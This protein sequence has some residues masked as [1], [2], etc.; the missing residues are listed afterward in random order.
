MSVAAPPVSEPFVWVPPG[1]RGSYLDEVADLAVM[2]GRPLDET[3]RIAVGAMSSYGVAGRWLTL[4]ALIKGPR[5]SVGKTGGIITAL[6]F[7]DLFL[8]DA[9]FIAWT[10][11]LFPTT[12]KAFADHVR[13]IEGCADLSRRVKKI[14]YGRGE[15]SIHLTNGA[16]LEYLARSKGGGRGMTGKTVVIDEAL[17]YQSEAAAA[18]LPTLATRRNARV[19][20]ASSGCKV[21]SALLRKLTRRGRL[22][23]DPS[24]TM[25]EHKARGEWDDPGCLQGLDCQ[26]VMGTAG[27]QLDNPERWVEANPSVGGRVSL[28]FLESMR[29]TLDPI[30]FGREFLGWDEAG[31][32]DVAHPLRAEDWAAITALP[33]RQEGSPLFF[34]TV[35]DGSAVIAVGMERLSGSD[36]RPHVELADRLPVAKLAGR[37]EELDGRWGGARFAAGKAGPVAGLVEA[38]SLPVNVELMGPQ[39]LAQACE[40]IEVKTKDRMWTHAADPD[41]DSSF[42]GAVSKPTGDGLWTWDWRRSVNLLP[43][44]AVTGALWM[45][46]KYGGAEP[47]VYVF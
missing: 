33:P 32:D 42:A 18:L 7:T 14:S 17:F 31:S 34:I 41:L 9:D 25:V 30:E 19:L 39:E 26:H 6:V 10:A 2:Y 22:R 36:R 44:A 43:V 12:R 1:A 45:V 40:H 3:Q 21:E 4:E 29:R 16:I 8:F 47:T 20:Y 27:C 24:L 38:R 5:Q 28:E 11:H 23:S 37:L 35:A 13:L 46:E 15:E